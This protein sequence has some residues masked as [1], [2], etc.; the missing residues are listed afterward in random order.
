MESHVG[1]GNVV[2]IHFDS[3]ESYMNRHFSDEEKKLLKE[4]RKPKSHS[5]KTANI[6]SEDVSAANGVPPKVG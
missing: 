1:K 3:L 2:K 4:N 5:K 6:P